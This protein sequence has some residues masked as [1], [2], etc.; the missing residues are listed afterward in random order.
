MQPL[1]RRRRHTRA[2]G[3]SPLPPL[4]SSSAPFL[5]PQQKLCKERGLGGKDS[6]ENLRAKLLRSVRTQLGLPTYG[7]DTV[8]PA[9]VRM[10]QTMSEEE[11]RQLFDSR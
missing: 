5:P 11:M 1:L 6:K 2:A 4:P 10:P 3:G 9:S 7:P 8:A